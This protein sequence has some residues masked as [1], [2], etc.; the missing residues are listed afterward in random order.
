MTRRAFIGL[1]GGAASWPLVAGAQQPRK[2]P[3]IGF[4]HPGTPELGS[5]AIDSLRDGL[6]ENGYVEGE[7]VKLETRWARGKPELLPQLTQELIRLGADILVP[8]ARPSMPW[9]T[10]KV[11]PS[12]PPGRGWPTQPRRSGSLRAPILPPRPA[13]IT[14]TGSRSI[15]PDSIR[16]RRSLPADGR[17][18][19]SA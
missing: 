17:R 19:I 11:F 15:S 5:Q 12:H 18:T 10:T 8:T 2:I 4:V 3:V 6:R 16:R 9:C 1:L 7:S 13:G 14:L